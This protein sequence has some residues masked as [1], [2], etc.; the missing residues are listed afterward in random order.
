MMEDDTVSFQLMTDFVQLF[1][2]IE[3]LTGEWVYR[4]LPRKESSLFIHDADSKGL[5][6]MKHIETGGL[7]ITA[8][9]HGYRPLREKRSSIARRAR[10]REEGSGIILVLRV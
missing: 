1:L 4:P 2:G 3:D 8:F 6:P 7:S 5:M 9:N 10:V